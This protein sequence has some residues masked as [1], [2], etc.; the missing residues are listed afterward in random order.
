ARG[1]LGK[2]VNTRKRVRLILGFCEGKVPDHFS[3][4]R[5]EAEKRDPYLEIDFVR[6]FQEGDGEIGLEA[7]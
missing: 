7:V 2:R 4:I 3:E 1:P 6:M 5:K